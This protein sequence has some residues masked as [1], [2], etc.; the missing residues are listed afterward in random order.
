[1][2]EHDQQI[3]QLHLRPLTVLSGNLHSLILR[4]G[5]LRAQKSIVEF[6]LYR[7][8]ARSMSRA[9]STSSS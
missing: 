5:S 9:A 1:M 3:T 7:P 8:L 4:F 6:E 2:I